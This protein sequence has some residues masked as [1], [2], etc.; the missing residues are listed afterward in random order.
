MDYRYLGEP[1]RCTVGNR[2]VVDETKVCGPEHQNNNQIQ[3]GIINVIDFGETNQFCLG[4]KEFKNLSD[5]H[6][7]MSTGQLSIRAQ[8][9]EQSSDSKQNFRSP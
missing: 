1:T 8:T 5:S 4:Y 6:V 9:L 3:W 2:E 7:E